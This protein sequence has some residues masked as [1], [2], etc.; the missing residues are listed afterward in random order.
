MVFKLNWMRYLLPYVAK[1][2]PAKF[3]RYMIDL[4][5]LSTP[6][7]IRAL[8]DTFESASKEILAQKREALL[9]G[10]KAVEALAGKGKDIMS[11][12]RKCSRLF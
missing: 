1:L 7:Q 11:I 3:R 6:K 9:G 8:S 2:G 5:P 10:G 12:L 4:I